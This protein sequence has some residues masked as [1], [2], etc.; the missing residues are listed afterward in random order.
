M[1]LKTYF[2]NRDHIDKTDADPLYVELAELARGCAREG[3]VTVAVMPVWPKC[4][5]CGSKDK[6]CPLRMPSGT[7]LVVA[8]FCEHCQ[9]RMMDARMHSRMTYEVKRGIIDNP[10]Q[11]M[12]YLF[13]HGERIRIVWGHKLGSE[14]IA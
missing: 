4:L 3:Y 6:L 12:A 11:D 7:T 2:K 9:R 8:L 14:V 10:S 13:A 1:K 5:C